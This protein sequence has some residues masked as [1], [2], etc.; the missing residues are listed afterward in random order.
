MLHCTAVVIDL[1]HSLLSV[2]AASFSLAAPA[3]SGG[4][5]QVWPAGS[6]GPAR[7][8][9][10]SCRIGCKEFGFWP[11]RVEGHLTMGSRSVAASHFARAADL[12]FFCRKRAEPYSRSGHTC[13]LPGLHSCR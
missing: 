1:Q 2:C 13:L 3:C 6:L 9:G 10:L 4:T 12:P 11:Q 7:T 5:C 8:S